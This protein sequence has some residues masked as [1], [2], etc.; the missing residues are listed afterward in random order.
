MEALTAIRMRTLTPQWE[1][2]PVGT[3]GVAGIVGSMLAP[4][5]VLN[6]L[7]G[8]YDVMVAFVL[9]VAALVVGFDRTELMKLTRY[10]VLLC[11]LNWIVGVVQAVVLGVEADLIHGL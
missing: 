11:L 5:G 3:L 6:M 1:V 2:S 9:L 4:P 10:L 8:I 7:Y